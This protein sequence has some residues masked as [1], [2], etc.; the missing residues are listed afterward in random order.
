M[1]RKSVEISMMIHSQ[2]TPTMAYM[3]EDP[4]PNQG[5]WLCRGH[6]LKVE[7]VTQD[8]LG[9]TDTHIMRK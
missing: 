6:L 1:I 3:G 8:R 2:D 7:L 4:P 5:L 9:N